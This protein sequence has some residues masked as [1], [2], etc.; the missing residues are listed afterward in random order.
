MN[1]KNIYDPQHFEEVIDYLKQMEGLFKRIENRDIVRRIS[2]HDVLVRGELKDLNIIWRRFLKDRQ[3]LIDLAPRIKKSLEG[4]EDI[5]SREAR[6]TQVR[7]SYLANS[8]KVDLKSLFLFGD[9]LFNKLVLLIRAVVGPK[10]GLEYRSFSSFLKS[11][12]KLDGTNPDSLWEH[13]MYQK[14]GEDLERIDVLLGFYRDKFIVHLS[15]PYQEGIVR[16]VYLPEIRLDHTS[17]K[18]DEFD[19]EKFMVLINEIG[20]IVP[21]E[22]KYGRPMNK[23]SDPRPKI[24]ALFMNLHR[25]KDP[26]LRERAEGYIRSIGLSTP[27]IYYLLKMSKDITIEI[28]KSL[29]KYIEKNYVG[30]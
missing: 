10:R 12:R 27:D 6:R 11:M 2:K 14:F 5:N 24:E 20:D 9:I 4:K 22:D 30:G 25:I 19:L 1:D 23:P 16:S 15:G 13:T 18:L 29:S 28:I 3:E 8:L 26:S 21:K 17:W 7:E